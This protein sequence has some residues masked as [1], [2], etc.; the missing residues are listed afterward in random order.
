MTIEI[1]E[2]A[3]KELK[4]QD[5]IIM[6]IAG[7]SS[8]HEDFI[9]NKESNGY[10]VTYVNGS[11]DPNNSPKAAQRRLEF[12]RQGE[13]IEKLKGNTISF[14]ELKELL[15]LSGLFNGV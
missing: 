13:L 10:R 14:N 5:K 11:D 8:L 12:Q 9:N 7:W 4:K 2:Y 6:S 1:K 3:T 15:R